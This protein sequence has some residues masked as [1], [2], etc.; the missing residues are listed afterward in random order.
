MMN[1]V[2]LFSDKIPKHCGLAL[3]A[4]AAAFLPAAEE[5]LTQYFSLFGM[6][7]VLLTSFWL[8]SAKS[9]RQSEH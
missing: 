7:F 2:F 4:L 3:L 8:R 1:K 5:T 6:G 9:Q